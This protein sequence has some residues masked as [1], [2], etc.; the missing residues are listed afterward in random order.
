MIGATDKHGGDVTESLYTPCDYAE[1]IY[2]K[3]GLGPE[4]RLEKPGG[5]AVPLSDGGKPIR[6]L[7]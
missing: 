3:L 4:Q 5:L 7:F 2:R 6:E 1:T